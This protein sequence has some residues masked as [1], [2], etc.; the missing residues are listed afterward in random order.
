M[1]L[2]S[3]PPMSANRVANERRNEIQEPETANDRT[4]KATVQGDP[5]ENR[6][7][8]CERKKHSGVVDATKN[9]LSNA[10]GLRI[11]HEGGGLV[12]HVSSLSL[13]ETILSE[14]WDHSDAVVEKLSEPC[15][16]FIPRP[17]EHRQRC[18][19]LDDELLARNLILEPMRL[20]EIV[21]LVCDSIKIV[22]LHVADSLSLKTLYQREKVF[23][24]PM[25]TGAVL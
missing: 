21:Y 15:V 19:K 22:E 9:V 8:S 12:I 1:A 5:R 23:Q 6:G 2:A 16:V 3:S 14:F 17:P 20:H 24:C 13:S 10:F 18:V 11:G 25:T 4:G 7:H